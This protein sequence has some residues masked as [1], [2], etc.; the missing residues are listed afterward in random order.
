MSSSITYR[1]N[2]SDRVG[3]VACMG[4]MI[5]VYKILV[6]KVEGKGPLGK[7]RHKQMGG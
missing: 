5:N 3:H 7:P 1:V 4:G 2:K 6:E